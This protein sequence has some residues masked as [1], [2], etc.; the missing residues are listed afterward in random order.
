MQVSRCSAVR[1]VGFL[2]CFEVAQKPFP[3]LIR[4]GCLE[5]LALF[6]KVNPFE[7]GG[8]VPVQLPVVLILVTGRL[9]QVP[10]PVVA[11]VSVSMVDKT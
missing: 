7:S 8:A 6:V 1:L 2:R 10:N 5:A 9:S 11:W 3:A 4:N